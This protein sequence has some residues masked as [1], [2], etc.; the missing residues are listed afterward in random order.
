MKKLKVAK[1]MSDGVVKTKTGK[2]FG[3]WFRILDGADAKK[4]PHKEIARY[5]KEEEK[6]RSW[7][8]QMVTVEYERARGLRKLYQKADGRFAASASRT[9]NAPLA[10]VYQAWA[11]ETQRRAW[12]PKGKMDVTTARENKSI[13]AAWDGNKGRVNIGFYGKSAGRCQVA[14]D[15][16]KL[17]SAS[18]RA[19]MKKYWLDALGRLEKHLQR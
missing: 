18:E 19:K 3:E 13:R 9:L 12:L 10:R 15:H 1:P 14:L 16:E 11:D 2:V 4:R 17:L 5:L 6:V 8:C 7:W